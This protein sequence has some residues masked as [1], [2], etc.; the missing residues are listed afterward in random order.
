MGRFPFRACAAVFLTVAAA[1]LSPAAVIQNGDF[2]AAGVSPDP[3]DGWT[4][5]PG[6]DPPADG[7]GFA[8]FVVTAG[9]DEQQLEQTFT[10]PAGALTLSFKVRLSVTS[11]GQAEPGEPPDS[12]QAVLYDHNFVELFPFPIAFFSLDSSGPS[13]EF[14]DPAFVTVSDLDDDWRLV[15]LN[16]SSVAPQQL[17]IEFS[18]IG[19][20]DGLRSEIHLD[21]VIVTLQ[22]AVDAVPE[23]AA[24][25]TWAAIL[26][27]CVPAVRRRRKR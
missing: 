21:D 22:P 27:L 18:Q 24:L 10:L 11:G 26:L 2:S 17:L 8:V 4:T 14:F 25:S 15:T 9:D 6:V 13:P 7:G 23:P 12:F 3:F 20:D 1:S 19:Q 5:F 16:I